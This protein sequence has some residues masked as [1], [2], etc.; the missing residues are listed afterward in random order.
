MGNMS[1]KHAVT[2]TV[3]MRP[4]GVHANFA[5]YLS[6][7]FE[8]STLVIGRAVCPLSARL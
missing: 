8:A 5:A 4:V 6:V 2:E 7:T 3:P 1:W